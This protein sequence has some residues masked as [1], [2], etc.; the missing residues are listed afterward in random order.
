MGGGSVLE[1][2]APLFDTC[3]ASDAVPEL[4][5]LWRAVADGWDPPATLTRETW[6]RLRSDPEPSAL[7]GWAAYAASYN[8]KYFAG[9]GPTAPGA[10]RDYL[11]ESRRAI[12]RKAAAMERVLFVCCDYAD[13]HSVAAD[14]VVYADPPYANTEAYAGAGVFDTTRFWQTMEDW[15]ASGALVLVHEYEAPDGWSVVYERERVETMHHGGPSSGKR[16]ER[17][18]ALESKP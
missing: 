18:F 7:K 3:M 6:E 5:C 15:S 2:V 13:H 9:Y 4:I 8:G 12:R 17:I 11:A 14:T 16:M 10:G 1:R